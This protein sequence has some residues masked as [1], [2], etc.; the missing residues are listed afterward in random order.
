MPLSNDFKSFI[1]E[2]LIISNK[3][4]N[5]ELLNIIKSKS[6]KENQEK[7]VNVFER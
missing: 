2:K 4:N 1:N 7:V 6:T 5:E 3:Y